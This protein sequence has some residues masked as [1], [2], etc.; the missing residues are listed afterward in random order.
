MV[1]IVFGLPGSGKTYF[2][3]RL[4]QILNADYIS[5]DKLRKQM[6]MAQTYSEEEKLK[7]YD[8]MLRLMKLASAK[9]KD[10]VLDATFH[11]NK[12]RN[13]FINEAKMQD[14]VFVIEVYAE[15]DLVKERLSLSRQDS[16]ADLE[17][18]EKIKQEWEPYY[19]EHLFL[20]SANNNITEMLEHTADY[21][22]ATND[23]RK[24]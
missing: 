14:Y 10:V 18:Y 11:K 20:R 15:E 1:V 13:K 3:N 23:K 9:N 22:F 7:V 17:V 24:Y 4:A 5:S 2:A 8:E 12:I 21:L 16:D 19:E 6:F